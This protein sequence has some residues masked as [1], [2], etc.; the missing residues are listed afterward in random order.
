M[1][2]TQPLLTV[3]DTV[4]N[5]VP[6]AKLYTYAAGTTTPAPV[7]SDAAQTVPHTNPVVAD[8]AG[9]LP[10][11]Y[12]TGPYKLQFA[13]A[14]NTI[15]RVIDDYEL[16]TAL[17][18]AAVANI[19]ALVA[20][21]GASSGQTVVV[22]G[23]RGGVWEFDPANLSSLVTADAGQ[24]AIAAPASAPTGASGAWR[25]RATVLR[26]DMSGAATAW[27]RWRETDA[28]SVATGI[29]VQVDEDHT[30]A[31][32]TRGPHTLA[33]SY[34]VL[35]GT[36]T[37]EGT[38]AFFFTGSISAPDRQW[39]VE[40]TGRFLPKDA[41]AYGKRVWIGAK[42]QAAQGWRPA[43][44]FLEAGSIIPGVQ[45]FVLAGAAD[46]T[47]PYSRATDRVAQLDSM[48]RATTD[49]GL[50]MVELIDTYTEGF[51]AFYVPGL[52]PWL[53]YSAL[54]PAGNM[55]SY[56]HTVASILP[57]AVLDNYNPVL[58]AACR[59]NLFGADYTPGMG[60]GGDI[61]LTP[62]VG[63]FY[64]WTAPVI[65]MWVQTPGAGE[66]NIVS[67]TVTIKVNSAYFTD[68]LA[69]GYMVHAFIG[70]R[71]RVDTVVDSTTVTCTV[72][73]V[74]AAGV[75]GGSPNLAPF[76][77][78]ALTRGRQAGANATLSDATVGVGRT[79]TAASAVFNL[80]PSYVGDYIR[81]GNGI[82][83]ITAVTSATVATVDIVAAFAGTAVT[84]YDIVR[85]DPWRY[86]RSMATRLAYVANNNRATMAAIMSHIGGMACV[87]RLHH[88]WEP[89]H[90]DA[91]LTYL[92]KPVNFT[93]GAHPALETYRT[94][95]GLERPSVAP[96]TPVDFLSR[97]TDSIQQSRY[98]SGMIRRIVESGV[99]RILIQDGN[100]PGYDEV[101]L[102][103]S[104]STSVLNQLPNRAVELQHLA[105]RLNAWAD[106]RIE[107]GWV[108]ESW[109]M[110]DSTAF[111]GNPFP[112]SVARLQ[113]AMQEGQSGLAPQFPLFLYSANYL[114]NPALPTRPQMVLNG[115]SD[116]ATRAEAAWNWARDWF[117]ALDAEHEAPMPRLRVGLAALAAVTGAASATAW[118]Y[119]RSIRP[120]RRNGWL[121]V[122]AEIA[123]GLS[124]SGLTE[125]IFN[126]TVRRDGID[127]AVQSV[128]ALVI[129]SQLTFLP[130]RLQH[131]VAV[132]DL[133][134][135]R[136][137][138]TITGAAGQIDQVTIGGVTHLATAVP[139]NTS[140]TE[141]AADL[142]RALSLKKGNTWIVRS[143]SNVV[144]V[145][146]LTSGT[147]S[148]G[149]TVAAT[150]SG[151]ITATTANTSGGT[152]DLS[153]TAG[154][155]IAPPTGTTLVVREVNLEV[156]HTLDGWAA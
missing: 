67:G 95:Y 109:T 134:R 116:W 123:P 27:D 144:E 64:Q 126:A 94:Q 76:N 92:V 66:N 37:L 96:A 77:E 97:D 59:C 41:S 111:Y 118:T 14:D 100:G 1:I 60:R 30:L 11:M 12:G 5:P 17:D 105:D 103:Y 56:W 10:T 16:A 49:G 72:L 78:W 20:I 146:A 19:A 65:S 129:S 98:N 154:V 6:G 35:R 148:N 25:R 2:L 4:G 9:R 86:N 83:K 140:T 80:G 23:A 8:A 152:A 91:G 130:V 145:V 79:F 13:A 51:G 48:L 46:G 15:I 70:G 151:G 82:A 42:P 71:A 156:N 125:A 131:R 120:Y 68:E 104:A 18:G 155:S 53:E 47:T 44:T 39:I 3:L 74:F 87:R 52:T 150:A 136:G 108:F 117:L 137:T 141:T 90:L 121:D 143:T 31:P 93:S 114:H 26:S 34:Q 106:H 135:A 21:T 88:T 28:A 101:I 81:A 138:I 61:S 57:G 142:A 50:G 139:Y 54:Y 62:D 153:I 128:S 132:K 110:A 40:G 85:T 45:T 133:G 22:S 102:G 63:E 73:E 89:S 84:D 149:V 32:V 58:L 112:Q 99:G 55:L 7:Y 43:R 119:G 75:V 113:A 69:L 147:A 33:A 127:R 38:A 115:I 36:V 24:V 29:P 107:C 122:V 124:V